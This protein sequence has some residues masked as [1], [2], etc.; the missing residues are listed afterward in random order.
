[1]IFSAVNVGEWFSV[2]LTLEYNEI[3]RIYDILAKRNIDFMILIRIGIIL[4]M[5]CLLYTSPSPRDA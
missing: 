4:I 5:V 1:M 2:K 3:I